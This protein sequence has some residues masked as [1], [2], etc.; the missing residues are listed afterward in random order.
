MPRP[1]KGSKM[2]SLNHESI[3]TLGNLGDYY[4]GRFFWMLHDIC[5][6]PNTPNT[7]LALSTMLHELKAPRIGERVSG[8]EDPKRRL[9]LFIFRTSHYRAKSQTL[10]HKLSTL[11]LYVD[12]QILGFGLTAAN[13]EKKKWGTIRLHISDY[14]SLSVI[15]LSPLESLTRLKGTPSVSMSPKP[16]TVSPKPEILKTEP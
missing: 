8:T 4:G 5:Q 10:S 13:P 6:S 3:T 1:P 11:N 15:P 2:E 16:S 7:L 9:G 14:I 12:L